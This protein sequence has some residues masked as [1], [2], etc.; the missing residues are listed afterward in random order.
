MPSIR[1]ALMLLLCT[2]LCNGETGY[3]FLVLGDWGGL[4]I[5]PYR[6]AIEKNVATGMNIIAGERKTQFQVAL[7]DNFYFSGVAN[8]DD[9]RFQETFERVFTG[10]NLQTPWYFVAG[11][12]DW[13]GNVSA[14]IAYT[15]KSKRWN[16]P[17][18]YYTKMMTSQDGTTLQLVLLDTIMLCGQTESD[19]KDE[20]LKLLDKQASEQQWEWIEETLASS[21]ADYLLVGGHFPVYSIA[22]HGPTECL[23]Q[24][25]RPLLHK[26]NVTA[27]ISGHDH[28]SQHLE[29]TSFGTTMNY[30]ILGSANF[31]DPSVQ[32]ANSVPA[33]SSKFHNADL[34]GAFGLFTMSK[35]QLVVTVISGK[36]LELYQKV[37][38][39][40]NVN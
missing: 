23:V 7:G 35:S 26:Y 5:S 1:Q 18:Y 8:V 20:L 13:N 37:L 15:A 33:N 28:N 6:T 17:D 3:N 31:A 19:F 40:R 21:K 14:Q 9:K 2:V 32:H 4:P 24:R 36:N 25:L 29:D 38:L 39:P 10:E 12:H 34:V 16:F 30:F 27:Y 22:E 11:N